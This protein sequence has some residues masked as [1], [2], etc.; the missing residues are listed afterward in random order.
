MLS[1]GLNYAG[2]NPSFTARTE[3]YVDLASL[4]T[5]FNI[6]VTKPTGTVD[7]DILFCWIG[8]YNSPNPGTIDST[9][10]GWMK[11][12]DY[13]VKLDKYALYYK[14]AASEPSSWTWSFTETVYTRAVCS[15]YTGGDFD[16]NDPIDVVSNTAY[17]TDNVN[18]IAASM[19]VSAI[20][21]PL[22]FW[23]GACTATAKTFAKP[24]VPTTD[25]IEDDDAGNT[26]SYF[27]TEVCSMIW[28]ES[29]ATGDMI[30]TISA[31]RILKHAFAVALNPLSVV[32]PT[33]TTQ[34]ATDV[35]CTNLMANGN[36]AATGGE[37]AH[38]RGF[39]Y[40]VGSSGDPTTANSTMYDNG[41][42]SYGTGTYSKVI[43]GLACNISYRVR[44]YA[45]NS[46]GT[47]YG[48]TVGVT[49]GNPG[50]SNTPDE[51]DFGI[52]ATGTTGSTA[53]NYFT[54]ENTGDCAVDVT[55]QGTDLTG[56]DDTWT[57]SGAATPCENIYGLYAGLDDADD[58]FDVVVNT[59]ANAFV[60]DLPEA[61]TQAWGLKL[62]MPTSVT[63]Y[64]A[65][66]MSGTI[67]LVASAA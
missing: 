57:L 4:T 18:C 19:A 32:A 42:G 5:P 41:G 2:A 6:T 16:P 51:Y 34:A 29:G 52:L 49:T 12:G 48:T 13:T 22:I 8:W 55:I 26:T 33:V 24:S 25:W 40:M 37:N 47:G 10:S 65:Q 64:D 45:I 44:A 50:I 31:T 3:T 27:W 7:G 66:Q 9:P 21:S 38:T 14:I 46:A 61:T 63:N 60:A 59:T 67:T 20:N 15:C 39:C 62:Y 1:I 56:G 43:T 58:N 30:A 23:G 54:L 36:I 11:L 53:I 28:S 35:W 17:R